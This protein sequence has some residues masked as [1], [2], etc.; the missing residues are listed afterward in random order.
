[1]FLAKVYVTLKSAV[2]DPQGLT[3]MGAL[4]QLGFNTASNVRIGK[5]LEVWLDETNQK[6]AEKR[7]EEMCKQLFSN[8]VIEE[9]HY[10][11]GRDTTRG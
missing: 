10:D 8:P 7:V 6:D 9:Y 2:N 11:I 1:M 4:K 5:Y 3:V